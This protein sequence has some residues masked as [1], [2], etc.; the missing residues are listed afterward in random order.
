MTI[1]LHHNQ[2]EYHTPSLVFNSMSKLDPT[3]TLTL[4]NKFA[5][6]MRGR[7]NRLQSVI[8][9]AIIN[10]DVFAIISELPAY[11]LRD[12]QQ[13]LSSPGYQ[14]F[15]FTRSVDK[16]NAFMDWLRAQEDL[17]I[18][19]MIQRP[20]GRPG[21]EDAWTD[22]YIETAYQKGIARA[23]Q[24][25]RNAGADIP[26]FED[27]PGGISA[28]M[29]GPLHLDRVGLIASRTFE[30]LKTAINETN[31]KIRRQIT[32]GLTESLTRGIAEGRHPT[33]I[34]REM[35]N[36]SNEALKKIG[37]NRAEMIART[38][39]IR[40]HHLATIAEYRDA[41]VEGV[42]VYAEWELGP[43][44]SPLAPCPQCVDLSMG[45]D[46]G[47]GVYSLGMIEPMIP[48]HPRSFRKDTEIL[49][50]KGYVNVQELQIGDKC[51]SLNPETF[52]LEYIDVINT[53]S[54]FQ[55]DMIHF[56]GR[57]IDIIVT[58]EHDMFCTDLFDEDG[59]I[60]WGFIQAKDVDCSEH[61]FFSVPDWL[62]SEDFSK[63]PFAIQSFTDD[64]QTIEYNDH[65]YCVELEKYHTLIAR[66]NGKAIVCGNCRCAALPYLP[67]F[68]KDWKWRKR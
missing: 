48:V 64:K 52:K 36:G 5:R 6:E 25:M 59:M 13:D 26:S 60:P 2:A 11:R 45:G 17:G 15:P 9:R 27:V 12:L 63:P 66:Y 51:L 54:H 22:I 62:S 31:T 61:Y 35:V 14:A 24:E 41:G 53:V 57:K 28:R 7:L 10:D 32:D 58:P 33:E 46:I 4:R 1:C 21:I 42:R 30:D 44:I 49:T 29:N 67:E 50:D 18:L 68:E 3:R 39:V 34:A 8:K 19:D 65:V 37:K 43:R 38:E 47:K 16:V 40:A 55:E 56:K 20:G 23:R